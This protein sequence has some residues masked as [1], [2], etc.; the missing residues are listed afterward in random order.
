MSAP[1]KIWI[2]TDD[3]GWQIATLKSTNADGYVVVPWEGKVWPCSAKIARF[4]RLFLSISVELV[5]D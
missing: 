5:W 1:A 3:D 4:S 2:L